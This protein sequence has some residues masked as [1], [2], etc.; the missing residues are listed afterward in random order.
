[1]LSLRKFKKFM[2][3]KLNRLIEFFIVW[4][5]VGVSLFSLFDSLIPVQ[6]SIAIKTSEEVSDSLP[7]MLDNSVVASKGHYFSLK[8]FKKNSI[9]ADQ[10]KN[11]VIITAYS[12]SRAETDDDPFIT[13]SGDWVQDG[14]VAANFLP[15]GTKIRIPDLYGNKTFV[16]KDRMSAQK[17]HQIDIWFSSKEDA[18]KFGAHYTY[19]EIVG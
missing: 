19:I 18:I 16:V 10:K 9:L 17:K 4:G 11:W 2:L 8:E 12:S 14:I 1:M 7:L 5:V 6:G 3:I 13:A 15:F